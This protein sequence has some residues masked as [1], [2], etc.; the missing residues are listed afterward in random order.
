M[1]ICVPTGDCSAAVVKAITAFEAV[2]ETTRKTIWDTAFEKLHDG[3][4]YNEIDVN[5]VR[6]QEM[7]DMVDRDVEHMMSKHPGHE[8]VAILKNFADMLAYHREDMITIDDTD[9]HILKDHLPARVG[10]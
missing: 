1:Q 4:T 5:N 9:F 2:I 3:A 7:R 10:T 6:K 8:T